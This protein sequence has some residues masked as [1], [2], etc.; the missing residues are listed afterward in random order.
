LSGISHAN[1]FAIVELM[2]RVDDDHIRHVFKFDQDDADA[3][4][5]FACQTFAI[6]TEVVTSAHDWDDQPMVEWYKRVRDVFG[7][8]DAR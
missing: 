4:A 1:L 6:G 7:P 2:E 3:V 5:A 8:L